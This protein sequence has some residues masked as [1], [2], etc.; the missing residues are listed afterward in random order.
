M[1]NLEFAIQRERGRKYEKRT[2]R[3]YDE[4][5]SVKEKAEIILS[6]SN[7]C[8]ISAQYERPFKIKLLLDN[9]Y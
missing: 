6:P 5:S 3:K 9:Y 7:I 1:V 2:E 8:K 4:D